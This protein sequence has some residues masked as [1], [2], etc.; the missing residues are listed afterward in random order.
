VVEK[1]KRL[2]VSEGSKRERFVRYYLIFKSETIIELKNSRRL[3]GIR[4]GSVEFGKVLE[5]ISKVK[6]ETAWAVTSLNRTNRVLTT[7]AQCNYRRDIKG[8]RMC[9]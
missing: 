6:P 3:T 8:S 5:R 4:W 9:K 7:S 2:L 1:V